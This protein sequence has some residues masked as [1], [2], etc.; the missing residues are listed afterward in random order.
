MSQERL[1]PERAEQKGRPERFTFY[2]EVLRT[3]EKN[4]I[5]H[6]V[7]GGFGQYFWGSGREPTYDLDISLVPNQ[8]GHAIK[9]LSKADERRIEFKHPD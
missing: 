3:L 9:T 2:N 4:D 1:H 8:V 7:I 6:G 5:P